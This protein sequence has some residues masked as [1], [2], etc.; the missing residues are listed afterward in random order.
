LRYY[1]TSCRG[2]LQSKRVRRS[3]VEAASARNSQCTVAPRANLLDHSWH[4]TYIDSTGHRIGAQEVRR[5]NVDGGGTFTLARWSRWELGF[6]AR[7]ESRGAQQ[8]NF[9]CTVSFIVARWAARSYEV[10]ATDRNTPPHCA[11]L[12]LR[13]SA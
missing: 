9:V 2:G 1:Q 11:P 3:G 4:R 7:D 10:R 5:S 13:K 12:L 6:E 8:N